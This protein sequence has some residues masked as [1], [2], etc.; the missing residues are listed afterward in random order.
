MSASALRGFLVAALVLMVVLIA[1]YMC[2]QL[3][4]LRKPA[5]PGCAP[6]AEGFTGDLYYAPACSPDWT[7]LP[8]GDC[9]G[10]S[11]GSMPSI[12]T[13]VMIGSGG[14]S[15]CGRLGVPP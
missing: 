3:Y 9:R 5:T 11:T 7:G 1:C 8:R 12:E 6:G 13:T 2:T 10:F 14:G 4:H 15:C